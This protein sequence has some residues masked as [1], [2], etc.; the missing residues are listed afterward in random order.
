MR[1]FGYVAYAHVSDELRRTLDKKGEKCVFVRYSD[2][3]KA[4]KL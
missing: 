3:S 4:Y 1:V 2:E